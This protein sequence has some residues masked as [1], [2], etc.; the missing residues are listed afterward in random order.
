MQ[1]TDWD[2]LRYFLAVSERGSISGAARFLNVNH[3]TVLRCLASLEKRLGARL[4]DRLPDGYE[5][6][7][8]GVFVH[9][10]PLRPEQMMNLVWGNQV[11]RSTQLL[12][13]LPHVSSQFNRRV[14]EEATIR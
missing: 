6:T 9:V 10:L 13:S 11:T 12:H 1:D 3:S 5:M 2:D 4:F 7:S 14:N 8:Q